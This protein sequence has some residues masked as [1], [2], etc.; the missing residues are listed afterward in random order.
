[1][2]KIYLFIISIPVILYSA[3]I[4]A[5]DPVQDSVTIPLKVRAGMEVSGPVIYFTDKNILNLEYYLL[6]DLNE[7]L[8]LY[9]AGGYSSY[10][11]SRYNYDYQS[12]GPFMRA[13]VDINLLKPETAKGKYWGGIGLHYG[14]SVF[15]SATPFFKEDDY[16]GTTSSSITAKHYSGHYI[17]VAP[18][19]RAE[20]FKNLS[21]G[22]SVS[23]R[24]QLFY[25]ASGDIRP[26]F[27]PGYGN[28]EKGFSAGISYFIVWNFRFKEIIVPVKQEAPE[29][30]EE[31][32]PVTAG[33]SN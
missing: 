20:L 7:R 30:T 17:E 18:G 28:G 24:K 16:W 25:K 6:G 10:S 1:M 32:A 3:G 31:T 11:Y 29:E 12:K 19:F 22:W 4:Q 8:S 14:M 2:K 33:R 9:V 5:Q 13:G 21:I 23:L 15:S 27:I 26:I